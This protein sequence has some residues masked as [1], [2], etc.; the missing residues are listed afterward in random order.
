MKRRSGSGVNTSC[1]ASKSA[2]SKIGWARA[3][4]A[5]AAAQSTSPVA[6][7]AVTVFGGN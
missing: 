1:S 7:M 4:V 3:S 5:Q 6:C 2:L